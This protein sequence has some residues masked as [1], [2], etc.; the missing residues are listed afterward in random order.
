[1]QICVQVNTMLYCISV[2][3]KCL[4][5]V[6]IDITR[7]LLNTYETGDINHHALSLFGDCLLN[8]RALTTGPYSV[9]NIITAKVYFAIKVVETIHF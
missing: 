6:Y 5:M 7:I 1:M 8:H 2:M 3:L 4:Y 9:K